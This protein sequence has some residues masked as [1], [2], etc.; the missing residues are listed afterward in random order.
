MTA[1]DLAGI[2]I[3]N[4]PAQ[5]RTRIEE[6]RERWHRIIVSAGIKAQ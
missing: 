6:E 4:S 5:A 1:P 2:P 3:G